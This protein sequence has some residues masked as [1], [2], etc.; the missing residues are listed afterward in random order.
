MADYILP[1]KG[2]GNLTGLCSVCERW[3]KRRVSVAQLGEWQ[4]I[5][6]VTIKRPG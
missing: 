3:M 4:A 1:E 5:L 2:A 6:D